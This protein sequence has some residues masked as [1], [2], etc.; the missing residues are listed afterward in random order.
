MSDLLYV[1]FGL[2]RCH[3]TELYTEL[4]FV[5]N[6]SNAY[7]CTCFVFYLFSGVLAEHIQSIT[8]AEAFEKIF[9][10]GWGS[11]I[12]PQVESMRGRWSR[13]GLS[14]LVGDTT[15]FHVEFYSFLA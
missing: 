1:N 6:F 10:H 14:E 7:C 8:Q 4:H 2:M 15:L 12:P 9:S 11:L 3:P 5:L 13:S